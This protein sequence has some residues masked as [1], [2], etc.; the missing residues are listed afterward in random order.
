[1]INTLK[2]GFAVSGVSPKAEVEADC[3]QAA[4]QRH[5]GRQQQIVAQR[6][7]NSITSVANIAITIR[8]RNCSISRLIRASSGIKA[9]G[10]KTPQALARRSPRHQL[11]PHSPHA[12]IMAVSM[13]T[14]LSDNDN[15]YHITLFWPPHHFHCADQ[16]QMTPAGKNDNLT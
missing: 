16:T 8:V 6:L 13:T 9:Q 3:R 1:M 11:T 5:A 2:R 14:S 7:L 12:A 15:Q 10:S 4:R